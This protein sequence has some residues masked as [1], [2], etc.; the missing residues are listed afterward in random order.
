MS[1]EP[2]EK[3]PCSFLM[4]SPNS[5]LPSVFPI[6]V[7]GR[8]TRGVFQV[9]LPTLKCGEFLSLTHTQRQQKA[10]RSRVGTRTLRRARR[11]CCGPARP[12]WHAPRSV[13]FESTSVKG[14]NEKIIE[15]WILPNSSGEDFRFHYRKSILFNVENVK[16]WHDSFLQIT[17]IG[18]HHLRHL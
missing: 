8:Q 10:P 16:I 11:G 1:T 18:N 13:R 5:N 6:S 12:P 3:A 17:K 9:A 7:L 15:K 4:I 14:S 2:L